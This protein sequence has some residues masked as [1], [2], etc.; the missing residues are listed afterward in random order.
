MSS[1]EHEQHHEQHEVTSETT[2]FSV[3]NLQCCDRSNHSSFDVEHVDVV[4]KGVNNGPEQERVGDLSME[5]YRLIE[6]EPP[7]LWSN[8]SQDVTA[9]GQ[10]N[11]CTIHR[12]IETSTTGNPHGVGQHIKTVKSGISLLL[13]PSYYEHGHMETLKEEVE[14]QLRRHRLPLDYG[15]NTHDDGIV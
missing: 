1:C 8:E 13:Q 10:Q 11:H 3:M 2:N 14:K 5:P 9:H 12:Q 7:K 15:Y 6:R 4:T